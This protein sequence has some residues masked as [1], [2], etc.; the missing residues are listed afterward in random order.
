MRWHADVGD[1]LFTKEEI[2]NMK[3]MKTNEAPTLS[4]FSAGV[5]SPREGEPMRDPMTRV[6]HR[7]SVPAGE[8]F[9]RKRGLWR[10]VFVRFALFVLIGALWPMSVS[11]A[12]S[13]SSCYDGTK[14]PEPSPLIKRGLLVLIDNTIK[15]DFSFEKESYDRILSFMDEGDRVIIVS[16]SAYAAGR[17]T[18]IEAMAQLDPKP[19][20][21]LA[22]KLRISRKELSELDDCRK[23]QGESLPGL[24]G[25]T[26][27]RV[28][29]VADDP[30]PKT[31]L[32]ATLAEVSKEIF[33]LLESE[34]TFLLIV[35]DMIENSDITR[36]YK[37]RDTDPGQYGL[38]MI[39]PEK[40]MQGVKKSGVKPTYKGTEVYVIG[41]GYSP[42]GHYRSTRIMQ[43]LE[44]FWK[45]YMEYGGGRLCNFGPSLQGEIGGCTGR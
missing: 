7:I 43:P 6:W 45:L 21:S 11:E 14:I 27:D 5:Q 31:A 34:E 19:E 26:L 15:F 22:E 24:I 44:K 30:L 9:P 39:D 40:E 38:R 1:P 28:Y 16:F 13:I 3:A 42:D 10:N 17:H 32:V 41:A 8:A 2:A 18:E 36:F 25:S 37:D 33:P 20:L 23:R 4:H 29:K 35:S 12:K